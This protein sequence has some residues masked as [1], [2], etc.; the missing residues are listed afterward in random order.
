MA[1]ITF[2]KFDSTK[3]VLNK[4]FKQH[5]VLI[6]NPNKNHLRNLLTEPF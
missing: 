2:D 3:S 4:N 6:G 5:P 1:G